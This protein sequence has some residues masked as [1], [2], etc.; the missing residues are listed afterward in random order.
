MSMSDSAPTNRI[1]SVVA[2][3]AMAVGGRRC[4]AS[5]I[6][7]RTKDVAHAAMGGQVI[8]DGGRSAISPA[9]ASKIR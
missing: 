2:C 5:N 8:E 4:S 1:P 9:S 6:T 3:N 7:A